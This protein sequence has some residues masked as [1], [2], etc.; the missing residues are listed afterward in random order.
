MIE[1]ADGADGKNEGDPKNGEDKL[2]APLD[3]HGFRGEG[4]D[5]GDEQTGGVLN[6]GAGAE[7]EGGAV[8]LLPHGADG[9]A[10]Q[11]CNGWQGHDE[12][13]AAA[14]FV[15]DHECGADEAKRE[16]QPLAR[17]DAL[18]QGDTGEGGGEEGLE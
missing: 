9:D 18:A 5:N 16:T 8:A 2:A 6:H 3:L 10:D 12:G 14:G 15:G 11:R 4:E 7:I 13:E 1:Q 17:Q